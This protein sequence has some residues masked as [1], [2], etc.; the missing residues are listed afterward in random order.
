ML[1]VAGCHS[2]EG[3][4]HFSNNGAI[5]HGRGEFWQGSGFAITRG[6]VRGRCPFAKGGGCSRPLAKQTGTTK[7][8]TLISL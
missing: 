5:W 4:C 7:R 1:Q 3:G 2:S 6:Q 8:I